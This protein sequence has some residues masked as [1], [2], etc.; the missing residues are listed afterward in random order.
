MRWFEQALASGAQ[1]AKFQDVT[2]TKGK[3]PSWLPGRSER[4][5]DSAS[6]RPPRLPSEFVE[7]VRHEVDH[8]YSA[9]RRASLPAEALRRSEFPG[10]SMPPG[11]SPLH[12]PVAPPSA[13][14]PAPAPPLAVVDPAL[15][16]AFEQAIVTLAY[17]RE[18]LLSAAAGE[19]AELAVLI[20]RRVIGRELSLDP[21]LVQNLVREGIQ[22]LGQH[23]RVLVRIG[24]AFA[25]AREHVEQDLH[26]AGKRFEVRI[27]AALDDYGCV[28]ETE[29]GR[30]DE[31]IESRLETLLQAL[32]PDSDPPV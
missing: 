16:Q 25:A 17:E 22:A 31:S 21:R 7:A 23:D 6:L 8:E 30:V 13:G 15:I 14:Q 12:S 11:S 26:D 10:A 24:K 1:R 19:L 9:R 5:P 32:R 4:R 27:D 2:P 29:L 20:A 18:R 28:I 3:D